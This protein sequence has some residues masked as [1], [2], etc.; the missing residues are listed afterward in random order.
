[1]II[2]FWQIF[3]GI[4]AFIILVA[5][6]LLFITAVLVIYKKIMHGNKLKCKNDL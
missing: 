3:V 1:M 4:I 2:T 6:V 5:M